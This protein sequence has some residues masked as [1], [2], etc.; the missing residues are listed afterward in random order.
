MTE[1]V[2]VLVVFVS[3][4][5]IGALVGIFERGYIVPRRWIGGWMLGN[6]IALFFLGAG[7]LSHLSKPLTWQDLGL[8]CGALVQLVY[9]AG[10][11]YWYGTPAGRA[12]A[13][14]M[15][16]SEAERPAEAPSLT[17]VGR[18]VNHIAVGMLAFFLILLVMWLVGG[19]FVTIVN[20]SLCAYRNGLAEDVAQGDHYLNDRDPSTGR[21]LHPGPIVGVPRA[22]L[23]HN[24]QVQKDRLATL[25]GL[26]C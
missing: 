10:L 1:A 7:N 5:G 17:E 13:A 6:A 22:T 3:F 19:Y 18:R 21:L 12:H 8:A 11:W 23:L 4:A 2:R 14:L 20:S 25:H 16:A 15:R 9:L 26:R 24:L